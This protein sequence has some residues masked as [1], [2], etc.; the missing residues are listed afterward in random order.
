MPWTYILGCADGTTYVGSTWN[1]DRRLAEHQAGEGAAYT[2]LRRRRPVRLLWSCHF[3]RI[4]EAFAFEKQVQGWGR[5]KR[6][7]LMEGRYEDL[8]DLAS[9][10]R[11]S[12]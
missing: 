1:L 2:R 3:E 6:L 9:R 8:P 12:G 11:R 4:D 10:P 7:A 5:A